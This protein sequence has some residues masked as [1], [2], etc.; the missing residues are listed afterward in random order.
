[1]KK[2]LPIIVFV[3]VAAAALFFVFKPKGTTGPTGSTGTQIS[4]NTG[5]DNLSGPTPQANP[6]SDDEAGS[7]EDL[8]GEDV[9]AE[10]VKSATEIYSSADQAL[11]AVKKAAADYDDLVLEQFTRPGP[12]C[13]W[14]DSFYASI[15]DLLLSSET[16]QEAKGYYAE[17]LAVSG[18]VD[19]IST[20]IDAIKNSKNSQES[21][22]FAEAIELATGGDDVV[23]FLGTQMESTNEIIQEASIAA[24]TNQGTRLAAELLYNQTQKAGDPDGYYSRGIGLGE[25]IPEPDAMPYLQ[26]LVKKQDQYSPLAVK[27]LINSGTD[28]LRL[29]IDEVASIKNPEVRKK[30]LA[31]AEE[32]IS[33]DEATQSY[34]DSVSKNKNIPEDVAEFAKKRFEE[35]EASLEEDGGEALNMSIDP[36]LEEGDAADKD[37]E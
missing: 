11:E 32:H 21:D 9:M 28:G 8:E 24:V 10:E 33:Y 12:E 29:V 22:I 34:L 15:K 7:S 14:C 13:T 31:G 17:L 20:L 19:N 30:L 4:S 27:A 3:I 35:G 5:T 25:F 26:E 37:Q 36:S 1:M 2:I 23:R 6:A 18:K 16:S